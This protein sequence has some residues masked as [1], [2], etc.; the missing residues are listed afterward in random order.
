MPSFITDGWT[1]DDGYIAAE[2]EQNNGERLCEALS[3]SYRPATRLEVVK[4][5]KDI[6]LLT[7]SQ[8]SDGAVKAERLACK[9]VAEHLKSWDL[10]D[11]GGHEV[12]LSATACER[13]HPYL[14][15]NLYRIVRGTQ[16]SDKKPDAEKEPL[17][18]EELQKN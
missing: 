2:P 8:D 9:F 4:L 18:D 6:E 14:F 17:T 10:K 3:F 11:P 13:I 5:D 12:K 16:A 1:R 15:G 7:K